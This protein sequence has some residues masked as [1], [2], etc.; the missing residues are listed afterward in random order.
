MSLADLAALSLAL[1]LVASAL[2]KLRDRAASESGLA[3]FG[4]PAPARRI[5]VVAL[6]A[7]EA[8]LAVG[9]ATG[10]AVA[11]YAAA[12]VTGAFAA[13]LAVAL[14]RGRRGAPCG[15][16]GARSRV[17]GPALARTAFLAAAFA[18]LPALPE[19]PLG[20]LGWLA[21]GNAAALVAIAGLVVVVLALARQVGELRL[22][23][24]PSPALEMPDEGPP[25]GTLTEVIGRFAPGPDARLA[26]AVFTSDACPICSALEPAIHA[27]RRDSYLAVEVFDELTD[28]DVWRALEVPGS[29]YAVALDLNGRVLAKGTFSSFGQLETVLAAAERREREPA[30]A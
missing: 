21:L 15:C 2:L 10:L 25:L 29:P 5:T 12:V 24:A 19:R 6:V 14:A 20:T 16:F 1:V 30:H 17:S 28:A 3:T 7:L 27:F 18:A 23:V 13:V 11:A 26:L 9:V 22:L 8:V 4:L